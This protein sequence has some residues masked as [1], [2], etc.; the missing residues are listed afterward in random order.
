M[1]D[2]DRLPPVHP[3]DVPDEGVRDTLME[4]LGLTGLPERAEVE[5]SEPHDEYGLRVVPFTFDNLLGE[6]VSGRLCLPAAATPEQPVPGVVC[7]PGTS[8]SAEE[9]AEASFGPDPARGGRLIGWSRELA[10]RGF[11]T[12]AI[13]LCGC[14][15]RQRRPEDWGLLTKRLAPLGRS[16]VGVMV[17]EGLRAA[18]L[19]AQTPGVDEQRLGTTGFS[20]GGQA[21]W[22]GL[23]LDERLHA[24]APL[25]GSLGSMAHVIRHGDHER[26]GPHFYVPHLL[27]HFDHDRI[28]TACIAPRPLMV[29]APLHDEDMPAS[30]VDAWLPP[31]RAAYDEAGASQQLR[32]ERPDDRHVF[33]PEYFEQMAVWM[34]EVM[35][36]AS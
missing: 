2:F 8:A 19:L 23:A 25:C 33:R 6:T 16:P 22:Y 1:A 15:A 17:D 11:A 7:L 3:V 14:T 28:T 32:V 21:A 10:R 31:V 30:G 34:G 12:A 9:L 20:L 29:L 27:R 5:S 24:A 4:L 35:G 36:H 26:H 13:T 18:R